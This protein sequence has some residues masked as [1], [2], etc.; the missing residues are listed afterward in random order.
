MQPHHAKR[1]FKQMLQWSLCT[2]LM[3]AGMAQAQQT[4][5]ISCSTDPT[6]FN[7]GAL[8]VNGVYSASNGKKPLSPVSNDDHW[9][10]LT[11][12]TDPSTVNDVA[13]AGL[14]YSPIQ[15]AR[16]GAGNAAWIQSPFGNAEWVGL[17]SG[18][19]YAVYR[20]D[21]TLDPA[22]DLASFNLQFDG[23]TDDYLRYVYVN[24]AKIYDYSANVTPA[25][26]V[27]GFSAGARVGTNLS[28]A[29]LAA[30]G[31]SWK[32]G[33]QVNSIYFVIKNLTAPT[34]LLVQT[35]SQALCT[36]PPALRIEKAIVP[37][38]GDTPI[39]NTAPT[40]A[41]N[42]GWVT[43]EVSVINSGS[44]AA[45]GTRIY[46]PLPAGGIQNP[47]VGT[48]PGG[49]NRPTRG[50]WKCAVPSGSTA[51]CP[52]LTSTTWPLDVTI[53][54]TGTGSLP[55]S[56]SLRFYFT[57]QFTS[58]VTTAGPFVI[59]NT[60]TM[61]PPSGFSCAAQ[62]GYPTPCSASASI[63]TGQM[64]AI[65]K[66][67]NT[68]GPL[69]PGEDAVYTVTVK[70]PGGPDVSNVR[71]TDPLPAGFESA[72]WTCQGSPGA[73]CPAPSG[74][75][76]PSTPLQQTIT[77]M[78]GGATVTYTIRAR[79]STTN[80]PSAVTDVTNRATIDSTTLTPQCYNEATQT[81]MAWTATNCFAT[82][83]TKISPLMAV[84]LTK[85]PA[86]GT[87]FAGGTIDYVV[88][89]TNVAGKPATSGTLSDTWPAGIAASNVACS[90]TD[91]SNATTTVTPCPAPSTLAATP[92]AVALKAG[93]VFTYKATATVPAGTTPGSFIDNKA[94]WTPSD[95]AHTTCNGANAACDASTRHTVSA[96]APVPIDARW[97]LIALS[98]LLA[99]AAAAHQQRAR[100][101]MRK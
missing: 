3:W 37:L 16:P 69:Y 12:A 17:N 14:T 5:V 66:S 89:V 97:M 39:Y 67:V 79:V 52:T 95:I 94:T 40:V 84:T 2:A 22:V 30:K 10:I 50:Q 70:N 93:D 73:G 7:T 19:A 71:V 35:T 29:V 91:A 1:S 45:N 82:A 53:G 80:P 76:N 99:L 15:V 88:T 101:G 65:T 21:F 26:G 74:T 41:T 47:P 23:Y 54:G 60:A 87:L 100:K 81:A 75:M 55:A 63:S 61:T 34:G 46:D 11:P 27:G 36:M 44:T 4:P 78:D 96:P 8:A 13:G 9:R 77:R 86:S 49:N 98:V 58:N 68:P 59:T 64:V 57:T 18:I 31:T 90:V 83:D 24:D 6:I 56:S 32:G 20:Y 62:P 42:N 38:P 25:G 43:Y 72:T 48:V 85:T 51:T 33:G 28:A 92:L